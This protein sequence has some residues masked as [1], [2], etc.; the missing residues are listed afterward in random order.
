MRW[1]AAPA[2]SSHENTMMWLVNSASTDLFQNGCAVAS[3]ENIRERCDSFANGIA[4]GSLR[5]GG[6]QVGGGA[7]RDQDLDDSG[8]DE[9]S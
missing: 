5:R 2:P 6:V 8:G 9:T 4:C 3:H 1:A 7:T